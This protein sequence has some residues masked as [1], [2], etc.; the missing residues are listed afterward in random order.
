MMLE[1]EKKYVG[2]FSASSRHYKKADVDIANIIYNK[3]YVFCHAFVSIIY[4]MRT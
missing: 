1:E 3:N 2:K 4:I